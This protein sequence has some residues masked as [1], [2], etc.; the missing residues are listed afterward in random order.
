MFSFG[1]KEKGEKKEQNT[2]KHPWYRLRD[3]EYRD[4]QAIRG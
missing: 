2:H 3:A 4:S 1:K